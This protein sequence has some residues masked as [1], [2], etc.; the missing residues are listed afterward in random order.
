LELLVLGAEALFVVLFLA[1]FVAWLRRRDPVSRDVML[2]F[3]ALAALFVI[4]VWS[5]VAPA[6]D[7]A[8]GGPGLRELVGRLFIVL[9]IFQPLFTLHLVS[10]VRGV[11]AW[12]LAAATVLSLGTGLPVIVLGQNVPVWAVLV[13]FLALILNQLLAAAFLLLE[14]NRRKGPGASRFAF[15]AVSTGLFAI[16][17]LVAVLGAGANRAGTAGDDV[18]DASRVIAGVLA[19]VAGIGYLLA[20]LPPRSLR[21]FWQAGI[22]L[23]HG[24][25]LV[26]AANEPVAT[27]WH[28][29]ATLA[30]SVSGANSAMLVPLEDGGATIAATAGFEAPAEL[31]QVAPDELERLR[32]GGPIADQPAGTTGTVVDAL[33]AA[34]GARFVSVVP[35]QRAG[36]GDAPVLVLLAAHRSLFHASDAE[37][38]A[39]LGARTAMEA[40][41]RRVVADQEALSQ[42]LAATNEVLRSA[43]QAKSDFLASMSHELRTPL[44][45]ILG[46]SDLMRNE[47]GQGENVVVPLEWV[48]LIHRGGEHLLS[49][50]NDVLD[51]AKVEAGRLDLQTEPVELPGAIRELL[52]GMRPLAER[53]HQRLEAN[54]PLITVDVDRGRLRQVLY[55]LL[56]NAIKYT[57]EGGLVRVDASE[58]D[59][60]VRIAVTDSGIG[61]AQE[62][63]DAVFEEFRQVGEP[64]ERQEGTGLGLALTRRLVE[65]HGGRIEVQSRRGEGSRFTVLLP[66]PSARDTIAAGMAAATRS[67]R[68]ALTAEDGGSDLLIIEDDPG[69]VRLLQEYLEPA[70]YRL[71]IATDGETGIAMAG[72]RAPAAIILDVLLP[73]I[74]GWEVLRRL[75]ETPGLRDVPVVIV[76]VIDERHV[77]LALGAADYLVKPVQRE[78]LLAP[79]QRYATA[80]PAP[81]ER[82]RVLAVDDEAAA[83]DLIR[84]ALAPER[85]EVTE[86]GS[87]RAALDLM[88]TEQFDLVVCDLDMPGIDGFEVIATLK[89]DPRTAGVPILVCTSHDLSETDK[90]RLNGK[91]LGI[92]SKGEAARDGLRSWLALVVPGMAGGP[93]E[94]R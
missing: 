59:G 62:D 54:A 24:R 15:A 70:G 66:S 52:N 55:N 67:R 64:S 93:A 77:G 11:P 78:A 53:K 71:R 2:T 42:R 6:A 12:V 18:R 88:A 91:I 41:R 34:A 83:R 72:A 58:E 35:V 38:L 26:S 92:V 29:Y 43:S 21:A 46:F 56:S 44:S 45:A 5:R 81:T 79:L 49:L 75:K 37:L 65:A 76:T 80:V 36:M 90:A 69:A 25:D 61:I 89:A 3:S 23:E 63:L 1:T 57:P 4:S 84:N 60:W 9:F 16:A 28:S 82:L 73:G 87:G 33:A 13:A 32:S 85:F 19:L 31:R 39:S 14:A 22:A 20:F 17:L 47:P 27:I 94:A 51:L 86:A 48:E 68:D 74:D 8:V 50:I 40:Q 10:L 30:A 7:P